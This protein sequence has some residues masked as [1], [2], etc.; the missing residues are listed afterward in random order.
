VLTKLDPVGSGLVFVDRVEPP[1]SA[2]FDLYRQ[3]RSSPQGWCSTHERRVLEH[4]GAPFHTR[5]P[6]SQET[7]KC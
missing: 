2:F 5:H 1:A 7:S 4:L 6:H 3:R